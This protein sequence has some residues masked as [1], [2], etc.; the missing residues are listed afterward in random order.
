MSS[1]RQ[2]IEMI[3]S[4]LDELNKDYGTALNQRNVAKTNLE[5]K[6]KDVKLIEHEIDQLNATLRVLITDASHGLMEPS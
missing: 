3:K 2:T 4:K 1:H 5:R 6:E